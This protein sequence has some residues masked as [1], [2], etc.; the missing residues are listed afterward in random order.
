MWLIQTSFLCDE[1][2]LRT[3][4][5]GEH[6]NRAQWP[7]RNSKRTVHNFPENQIVTFLWRIGNQEQARTVADHFTSSKMTTRRHLV[8]LVEAKFTIMGTRARSYRV[9]MPNGTGNFRNF[10]IPRKNKTT[11]TTKTTTSRCWSK[12]SKRISGNV[13]FHSIL[14]EN[15]RKFRSNGTRLLNSKPRIVHF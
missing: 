10:Q 12:F 5:A 1:R 7:T 14:N 11:K 15:F 3:F 8:A 13:L 6:A 9:E 2:N 4:P